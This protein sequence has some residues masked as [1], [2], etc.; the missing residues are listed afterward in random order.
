MGQDA[1]TKHGRC[2]EETGP[3]IRGKELGEIKC[4]QCSDAGGGVHRG[5]G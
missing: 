5:Q 1:V 2:Q 4:K 3:E